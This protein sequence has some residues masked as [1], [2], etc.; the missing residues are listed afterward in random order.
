M[1]DSAWARL[2]LACV[3]AVVVGVS[4]APRAG[5]CLWDRDTLA[6]EAAGLPGVVNIIVGRFDRWPDA[7]YEERLARVGA[8]VEG[9]PGRLGLYDDAGVAC[10]KLGRHGEAVEWMARKRAQLDLLGSPDEEHEYRYHANLGTFLIHR[11]I[12]GGAD[13]GAMGDAHAARDH[14][15][16]AIEI[17]ADAHFGREGV[18]LRLIEWLIAAPEGGHL[19]GLLDRAG[20]VHVRY[21]DW[22][23]EEGESEQ[24]YEDADALVEGL[25]GLI[26][27][28]NAWE[29]VDVY[30]ALSMALDAREDASLAV[31]AR[32]R[33][34]ELIDAGGRSL[35]P[36]GPGAEA[37]R[38]EIERVR[39]RGRL[40][41]GDELAVEEF[42]PRARRAADEWSAS[43][44]AFIGA[45]L[46]EGRH[47][48]GEGA[49]SF[50]DGWDEP[51]A[52]A[53][54]DGLLGMSG[55]TW[56]ET[57]LP[58]TG[59]ALLGVALVVAI[60]GY[61]VLRA[62]K[63]ARARSVHQGAGGASGGPP[64]PG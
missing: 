14:I 20:V 26:A 38:A 45:R 25:T 39:Y 10:D 33:V 52:P 34:A 35:N 56:G 64:G 51:A 49:E 59:L 19:G 36:N 58:M 2:V 22:W 57:V 62:R 17:N 5:A 50:W 55:R 30:W 15:A 6:A 1:S 28:G 24:P 3:A 47:P 31:L 11:W 18:Q 42:Y 27:L 43:R 9:E 40:E 29:S 41:E 44:E 8:E 7:V 60:G 63:R 16:R 32:L 61:V 13:R 54:P 12:A 48:D 37:I 23:G 53:L 46:D 4:A 21:W